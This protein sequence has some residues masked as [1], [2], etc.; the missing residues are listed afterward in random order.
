MPKGWRTFSSHQLAYPASVHRDH[1]STAH[2][3]CMRDHVHSRATCWQS[4]YIYRVDEHVPG[5][6][7]CWLSRESRRPA[8]QPRAARSPMRTQ[9]DRNC[10]A[11]RFQVVSPDLP[12]RA[13][14]GYPAVGWETGRLGPGGPKG[15]RRATTGSASGTVPAYRLYGIEHPSNLGRTP[16]GAGNSETGNF[17]TRSHH[18]QPRCLA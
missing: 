3:V 12:G 10:P 13:P 7:G 1:E 18:D 14:Q 6:G 11:G 8:R 5:R 4:I 9:V 16:I 2:T 15:P 17:E